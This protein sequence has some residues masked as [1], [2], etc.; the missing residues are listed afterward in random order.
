MERLAFCVLIKH[1]LETDLQ[2]CKILCAKAFTSVILSSKISLVL[3][4]K[5]RKW[6][7][8]ERLSANKKIELNGEVI[9]NAQ[10]QKLLGVHIDYKLKFNT[11]NE[12]LCEKVGKKLHALARVMK[13][14]SINQAKMLMRSFIMSQFSYC[15]LI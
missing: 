2:K 9:S 10:N 8:T 15:P 1:I 13:Y 14:I 5:I 11:H 3:M 4:I 12:I 7:L 6:N